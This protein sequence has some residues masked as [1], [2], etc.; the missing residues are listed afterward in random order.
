V[1]VGSARVSLGELS[2][3]RLTVPSGSSIATKDVTVRCG[4]T[5]VTTAAFDVTGRADHRLAFVAAAPSGSRI[6][7]HR[8]TLAAAA[9]VALLMLFLVALI[10]FPADWFNDTYTENRERLR[11]AVYRVVGRRPPAHSKRPSRVGLVAFLVVAGVLTC[12]A[13]DWPR[14]DRAYLWALLGTTIGVAALTV[15]FQL[16]S[17]LS[18]RVVHAPGR[19]Q[20]LVGSVA[21]AA[22]CV[23]ATR[24]LRLDPPYL[25][26]LIAV[27]VVERESRGPGGARLTALGALVTLVLS[28]GAW[29]ADLRIE[30]VAAGAS[31][32]PGALVLEAALVTVFLAGLGSI[33]FALVPL[34]FLPG[35]E[36]WAWNRLAWLGLF[37]AGAYAFAVIMLTPRNGYTATV[38]WDDVVPALLAFAVFAAVSVSFMAYFRFVRPPADKPVEAWPSRGLN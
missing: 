1:R 9:L 3:S 24:L 16:P 6:L 32:S 34:P 27:F 18:A 8:G 37:A 38:R 5:V 30:P 35:C 2:D 21:V 13:T 25:Y 7:R 19:L 36:I 14:L 10:G 4:G 33:V 15:G 28:V 23:A 17:I 12:A 26:G 20:V 11:A 22:V 29:V 31:P